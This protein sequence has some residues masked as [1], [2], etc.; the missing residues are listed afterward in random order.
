MIMEGYYFSLK[1]YVVTPHLNRLIETVQM[2]GHNKCFYAELII[3]FP[4]Y[5]QIL[6]F[7][8]KSEDMYTLFHRYSRP[9]SSL[10]FL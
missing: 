9:F 7:I 3:I 1:P 4:N 5:H 8:Q 2:R 10:H 6:P